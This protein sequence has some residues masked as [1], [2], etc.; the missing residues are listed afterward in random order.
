MK[1]KKKAKE[2]KPTEQ[3]PSQANTEKR[4]RMPYSSR[5]MKGE[6]ELCE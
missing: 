1:K 3:K 6:Q 5:K 4:E 2:R